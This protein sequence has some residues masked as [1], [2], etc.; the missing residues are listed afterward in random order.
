MNRTVLILA[1]YGSRHS[2]MANAIVCRHARKIA[3]LRLFDE[4][5]AA[6]Y[7][8]QPRFASVLDH[9]QADDVTVV[10][11]MTSSG[12]FCDDVLSRELAKNRRFSKIRLRISR[13]VGTHPDMALLVADRVKRTLQGHDLRPDQ[14]ALAIVGHGT[15]RHARSRRATESLA[16]VLQDR[17]VC[18]RVLPFFLDEEPTVDDIYSRL[19]PYDVI[20]VPFLIGG[21]RHSTQ[22]IPT[23]LGILGPSRQTLPISRLVHGRFVVCDTPVGTDP[24]LA[25]IIVQRALGN[26]TATGASAACRFPR[27]HLATQGKH[28]ACWPPPPPGGQVFARGP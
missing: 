1:A 16:A 22:D 8:G 19:P 26:L 3:A 12:L 4:V 9:V 11:V 18:A 25:D 15:D 24:R 7:L 6:F 14:T 5:E 17:G 23:R 2:P 28:L 20:V 27:L 21:G 13:P 10:P